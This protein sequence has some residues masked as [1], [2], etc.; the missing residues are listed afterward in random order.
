MRDALR[1]LNRLFLAV[2]LVVS[3]LTFGATV[4]FAVLR[5]VT[6]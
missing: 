1:L 3:V 6:C 2:F 5:H 4:A